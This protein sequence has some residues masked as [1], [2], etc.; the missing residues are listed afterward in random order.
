MARSVGGYG[1]GRL[2]HP[3]FVSLGGTLL[4]AAF[5]TDAMYASNALMQW[6]NFSAWLIVGGLVLALISV[7]A[8]VIDLVIG[9]ASGIRGLDFA[10]VGIA[11]LVSLLNVFVH[12]RDAWTSVVPGGIILSAIAA[13]LLI[14]AGL[15][16][17]CVTGIAIAR[18]GDIA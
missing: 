12:T 9:R 15:R 8:L 16:G 14:V 13:L 1:G 5:F 10:L 7:L 11:A 17:W 3:F 18:P 6:A 2:L 4:I